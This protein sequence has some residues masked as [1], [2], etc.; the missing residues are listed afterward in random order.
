MHRDTAHAAHFVAPRGNLQVDAQL[1]GKALLNALQLSEAVEVFQAF[2]QAL[3]LRPG[4]AQKAQV[5]SGV[6]EQTLTPADAG[7]GWAGLAVLKGWQ[8]GLLSI[9]C[10]RSTASL[11][12]QRSA[13]LYA[14]SR[15]SR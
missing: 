11:K 2:Q 13:V 10:G 1:L 15:R 4:Q 6:V 3:L 12:A 14:G 5:G 9:A 7:A 8:H